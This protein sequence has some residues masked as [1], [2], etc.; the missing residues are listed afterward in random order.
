MKFSN[1]NIF[2]FIFIFVMIFSFNCYSQD[3]SHR[4][5]DLKLTVTDQYGTPI[6]NAVI[7]I[8]MKKH[9]FKFG[10]Q[11]RDQFF[12]ITENSFNALSDNAKQNLLPDLYCLMISTSFLS[13]QLQIRYASN[14]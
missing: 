5:S 14:T 4:K 1:R 8:Q 3:L 2:S 10:T 6:P 9:A 13:P 7:D 12:S 11:V